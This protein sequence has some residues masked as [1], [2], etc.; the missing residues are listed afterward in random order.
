MTPKNLDTDTGPRRTEVGGAQPHGSPG[1]S[2][3]ARAT[4]FPGREALPPDP[5]LADPQQAPNGDGISAHQH[6]GGDAARHGSALSE[7]VK[8]SRCGLQFSARTPYEIWSAV[9][10]RIA[11]RSN[12]T[13]W[14]LGHWVV[15]GS[16]HCG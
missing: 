15:F 12:A 2:A 7:L 10:A 1:F 4:T 16:D 14:W 3:S 8:S 13:S 6:V 5:G 9:G 11:V